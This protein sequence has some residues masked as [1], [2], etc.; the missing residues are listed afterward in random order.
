MRK[1]LFVVLLLSIM[2][3]MA[4]TEQIN[5]YLNSIKRK[6]KELCEKI[7]GVEGVKDKFHK[8]VVP[9]GQKIKDHSKALVAKANDFGKN[10]AVPHAKRI[11]ENIKQSIS[12]GKEEKE[13]QLAKAEAEKNKQ[14]AET[15][16]IGEEAHVENSEN[17]KTKIDE[18]EKFLHELLKSIKE[19]EG[20][21]GDFENDY[22]S[23]LDGELENETARDSTSGE[24]G[25]PTEEDLKKDL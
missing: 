5:C 22:N 7:G 6:A 14:V 4:A 2:G 9:V 1:G 24:R 15:A 23:D 25:Q 20:N 18:L 3:C 19:K 12:K 10:Q 13:I 16:P 17:E 8:H 21:H 11:Y